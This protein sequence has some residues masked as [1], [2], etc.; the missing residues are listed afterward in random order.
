M[1]KNK[2]QKLVFLGILIA[3]NVLLSKPLSINL[4]TIR[5]GFGFLPMAFMG[6][7]YGPIWSGVA[8]AIADLIGAFLFPTGPFFPG[9]TLSAFLT[10]LTFG[11]VFQNRKADYKIAKNEN[12]K[13]QSEQR[14]ISWKQALV[15][16]L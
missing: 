16:S 4:P 14:V 1:K 11:V 12:G 8:C 3:I 5:I 15:A 2:T 7:I 9:F 13:M 10:G 6:K